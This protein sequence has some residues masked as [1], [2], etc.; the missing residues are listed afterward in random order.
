MSDEPTPLTDAAEFSA[1]T[2]CPD[3][4]D[5]ELRVVYSDDM[6]NLERRLTAALTTNAGLLAALSGIKTEASRHSEYNRLAEKVRWPLG[7]KRIA[8][9]AE[10]AIQSARPTSEEKSL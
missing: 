6:R 7:Y 2:I 1:T 9:M 5:Y 8:E 4:G 3:T 10:T